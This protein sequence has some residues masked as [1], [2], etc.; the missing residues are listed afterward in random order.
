MRHGA[1]PDSRPATLEILSGIPI[2]QIDE[3]FEFITPTGAAI[4]AGVWRIVRT[5][6]GASRWKIGYRIGSRKLPNRPE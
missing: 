4:V 5:D 2:K 3:P 6:A 1:I